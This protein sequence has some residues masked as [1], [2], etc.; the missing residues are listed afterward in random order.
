MRHSLWSFVGLS[1][2]AGIAALALSS[3]VHADTITGT[4]FRDGGIGVTISANYGS[5]TLTDVTFFAKEFTFTQTPLGNQ[6]LMLDSFVTYCVELGQAREPNT[7]TYNLF[8]TN[9]LT[10]GGRIAYLYNTYSSLVTTD[11]EFA[12]LQTAIWETR[13]DG[14]TI[15]LDTGNFLVSGA[16]DGAI[17]TQALVYLNSIGSN[18]SEASFLQSDTRQD[19]VGPRRIP[20]P[21][22]LSLF[23]LSGLL[24]PGARRLVR[25]RK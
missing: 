19:L 5:G 9:D 21:G 13:Y 16:G 17:K 6:P 25:R 15:D 8:S 14:A 12:A 22:T 3:P 11:L 24:L 4:T 10:N 23:A 20:E 1:A 7:H 18:T 2:V